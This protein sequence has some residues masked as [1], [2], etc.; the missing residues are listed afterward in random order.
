MAVHA[1]NNPFS[2]SQSTPGII[3]QDQTVSGTPTENEYSTNAQMIADQSNQTSGFFQFVQDART[4]EQ[5]SNNLTA[6]SS[7]YEYLGTTTN[8]ISDYRQLT[9]TEAQQLVTT[10]FNHLTV[11]EIETTQIVETDPFIAVS[12]MYDAE[13]GKIQSAIFNPVFTKY[14]TRYMDLQPDTTL[15][16]QFWNTSQNLGLAATITNFEY[17]EYTGTTLFLKADLV[18]T[19]NQSD[20]KVGDVLV[21]DISIGGVGYNVFSFKN[22]DALKSNDEFLED[23]NV[24]DVDGYYSAGDGGGGQFYWDA[25]STETDNGG[26]I[27][28]ATSVATGRWKRIYTGDVF[29]D[30]FGVDKTGVSDTQPQIQS[31]IDLVRESKKGRVISSSGLYSIES[32]IDL[33]QGVSWLGNSTISGVYGGTEII[34]NFSE[35]TVNNPPLDI[36]K[37]HYNTVLEF[38]PMLYNTQLLTQQQ[39]KGIRFNGN[40]KNVYG[41]YINEIFYSQI[42]DIFVKNCNKH[43]FTQIYGQFCQH[44]NIAITNNKGAVRLISC[45]TTL[46]DGLDV[47]GTLYEGAWLQIVHN[48]NKTGVHIRGLHYEELAGGTGIT[49]SDFVLIGQRGVRITDDFITTTS[50][51]QERYLNVLETGTSYTF[52]GVTYLTSQ[53]DKCYLPSLKGTAELNKIKLGTDAY[54]IVFSDN[55][56][57][58][59]FVNFTGSGR[60]SLSSLIKGRAFKVLTDAGGD[61]FRF[62]SDLVMAFYDLTFEKSGADY[63]INSKGRLRFKAGGVNPDTS[64]QTKQFQIY[65][66]TGSSSAGSW[67]D[68]LLRLGGYYMWYNSTG[69]LMRST[70]KSLPSSDADGIRIGEIRSGAGTTANRPSTSITGFNYFDTDLNKPIWYNGSAWVD[71][72]GTTV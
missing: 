40:N 52:D 51:S 23:G 12:F 29:T 55:P 15:T 16:L 32:P 22:V 27:I 13:T 63:F 30:W 14:L 37:D 35:D 57:F 1:S 47:E 68:G 61:L 9:A 10:P 34:C 24:V 43:P 59:Q 62:T 36:Y 44:K 25:T 64:V 39:L 11:K 17:T 60:E 71:A 2:C 26:T 72:T 56:Q 28:K 18:N 33:K 46:I 38:A 70:A 20:V 4:P 45:T 66:S 42:E 48:L 54:E 41:V 49:N 69:V 53:A 67:N 6:Y 8:N 5:I 31:A 21:T 7:Y 19:I 3:I 65:D 50:G 58:N